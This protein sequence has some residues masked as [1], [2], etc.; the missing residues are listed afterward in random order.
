M[1]QGASQ[2]REFFKSCLFLKL[3]LLEYSFFTMLYEFLLYSKVNQLSVYTY[4]F[5]FPFPSHLVHHRALSRVPIIMYNNI[6]TH[7]HMSILI[8]QFIHPSFLPW[9]PY[10]CSLHLC[11]YF[12]FANKFIFTIFL[13]Y[14]FK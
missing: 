5:F 8:Y 4:P 6:H 7:T 12:C 10:G 9:Y 13:D 11:L 14:T 2:I 1:F 3:L